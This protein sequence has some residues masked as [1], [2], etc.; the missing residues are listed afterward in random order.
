VALQVPPTR[1]QPVVVRFHPGG[2]RGAPKTAANVAGA[3]WMMVL[4]G[5]TT[6]LDTGTPLASG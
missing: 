1:F 5:M 2:S 6:L 3:G 4:S